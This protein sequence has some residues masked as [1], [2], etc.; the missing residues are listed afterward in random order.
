[1]SK[2]LVG[3]HV[4]T[5][6][7]KTTLI[8]ARCVVFVLFSFVINDDFNLT[9][10]SIECNDMNTRVVQARRL[11]AEARRAESNAVALLREELDKVKADDQREKEV[12]EEV[13]QASHYRCHW[14][15]SIEI[16]GIS[17]SGLQ[18]IGSVVRLDTNTL[19]RFKPPH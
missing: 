7:R 14:K 18:E 10:I 6:G 11:T 19:G 9:Q 1:M 15:Y 13:A 16:Y 8:C 12:A 17:R 3:E 2:I 4:V 5:L